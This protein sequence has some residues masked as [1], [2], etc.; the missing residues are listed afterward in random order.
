MSAPVHPITA[1][2][3]PA[4]RVVSVSPY[5]PGGFGANRHVR[6]SLVFL[7]MPVLQQLEAYLPEVAGILDE[8]P[9]LGGI[10]RISD[11]DDLEFAAWAQT[12]VATRFRKS[13]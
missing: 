11:Q 10:P 9:R 1:S 4:H 6:Q 8:C 12:L 2:G 5:K 7:N 3:W 13:A